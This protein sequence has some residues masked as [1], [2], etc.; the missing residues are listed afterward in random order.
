MH[1]HPPRHIVSIVLAITCVAPVL[2]GGGRAHAEDGQE[3]FERE[4]VVTAYYS[5]APDQCCYVR[6]SIAA[7]KVLNGEG[8]NGADGTPVYEGM[9]AAPPQYAFGTRIRLPGIGIGTVH[10]RGGAIQVLPGGVHRLDLWVGSGEEGLARALAFGVRKITATVYPPGGNVPQESFH[11]TSLSA[12]YERLQAFLVKDGA[13]LRVERGDRGLSVALVQETLK[14]LGY[15]SHP[16]T[17]SF[18][19][20]TS[21]ALEAF[22]AWAGLPVG[23]AVDAPTAHMLVAADMLANAD[24]R[25]E[26]MGPESS[27]GTIREAKRLLRYLGHYRGRT[28]G[29]YNDGLFNAVLAFQQA[30]GLVGTAKDPGAG[31]IGPLTYRALA[32]A[33]KRDRAAHIAKR[34]ALQKNVHAELLERYLLPQRFLAFGDTGRDVCVLQRLLADRGYFPPEKA[35]C[36][37]GPLTQQSMLRFQIEKKIVAS[38]EDKGGGM[39]GPQTLAVFEDEE[40]RR[41]S[42]LVR[43]G[44]W[45]V[46]GTL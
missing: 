21:A 23:G 14:R 29:T 9:I 25:P 33:W 15:F 10:D 8:R 3:P 46:L 40:V 16:V 44:G 38:A 22:Q 6:G 17:G 20:V 12:P 11:L 4:F 27:E 35:N 32:N 2:Q 19:D 30:H 18:G 1:K 41:V 7:D 26:R 42:A 31:R 5:P 39:L 36:V 24:V 28:D 13:D 34:I 43:G 45:R 37:F